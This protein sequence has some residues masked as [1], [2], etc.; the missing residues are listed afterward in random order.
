MILF[1][2]FLVTPRVEQRATLDAYTKDLSGRRVRRAFRTGHVAVET[3]RAM[4]RSGFNHLVGS[5]WVG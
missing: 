1:F 3:S 2:Y 4:N 5:V